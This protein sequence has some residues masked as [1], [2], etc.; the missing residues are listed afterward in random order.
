[1]LAHQH[2][3]VRP[4][5]QQH[6]SKHIPPDPT[7]SLLLTFKVMSVQVSQRHRL[8]MQSKHVLSLFFLD[9]FLLAVLSPLN[10]LLVVL[11]QLPNQFLRTQLLLLTLDLVDVQLLSLLNYEYLAITPQL[12]LLLPTHHTLLLL[13][14]P[15]HRSQ[16]HIPHF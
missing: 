14:L 9:V 12:L 11:N 5:M 3:L 2:S 16:F 15:L 6:K 4:S 13:E 7:N 10:K 8:R 1:M